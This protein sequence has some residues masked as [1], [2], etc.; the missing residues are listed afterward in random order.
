MNLASKIILAFLIIFAMVFFYLA[1]YVLDLR[2]WQKLAQT[3]QATL[4]RTNAEAAL[5]RN[6][7]DANARTKLTEFTPE[8]PTTPGRKQ[9]K[10]ELENRMIDRGRMWIGNAAATANTPGA[11]LLFT[12]QPNPAQPTP[13]TLAPKTSLYVFEY[14]PFDGDKEVNAPPGRYLGEFVVLETPPVDAAGGKFAMV[15]ARSMSPR[16][17]AR[18]GTALQSG[19]PWVAY[20]TLPQDRHNAFAGLTADDIETRFKGVFTQAQKDEIILD[21]Q[22]WEQGKHPE[23]RKDSLE[24]YRRPLV[25]FGQLLQSLYRR[26]SELSA[27]LASL[28]KDLGYMTASNADV[29]KQITHRK[30]E[31]VTLQQELARLEAENK[32]VQDHLA[33]VDAKLASVRATSTRL[34]AD[35]RK[36]VAQLAS[37]QRRAVDAAATETAA[38]T[39]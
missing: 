24:K 7:D 31:V 26:R 11:P 13:L 34:D 32:L 30:D 20:E 33:A 19:M 2:G 21:G 28:E 16:E 5:L 8:P 1:M 35:N 12:V 6:S 14:P 15:P 22:P 3:R 4:N 18:L 36:L 23:D 39:P 37:L 29:T 9:L 10:H 38:A 17:Q 25:D 27:E